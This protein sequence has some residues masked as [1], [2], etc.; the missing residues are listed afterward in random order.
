MTTFPSL[1]RCLDEDKSS[2]ARK[3]QHTAKRIYDRL[4]EERH[5]TGGESTIR[6]LVQQLKVRTPE[7]F[8]PLSFPAGD[9]V[10]VD[11]GEAT[12]YLARQKM[13][14]NLFCADSVSAMLH[15]SFPTVGKIRRASLMP[16]FMY[17]ITL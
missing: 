17:S 10:Q 13:K 16:L 14:V 6:R 3:Q 5:F 11:W 2:G 1:K 4:E 15:L 12:I 8:V 9:A 7:A